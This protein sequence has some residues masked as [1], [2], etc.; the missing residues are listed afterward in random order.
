MP[1]TGHLRAVIQKG[2]KYDHEELEV[3]MVEQA[4][5]AVD[6]MEGSGQPCGAIVLECTQMPPFAEAIQKL[7][8]KPVYDVYTMGMWFYSG[9]V[10]RTP[11]MWI[12][13]VVNGN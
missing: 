2:A 4:R 7:T 5:Y 8:G 11:Q 9:L 6:D 13:E 1:S 12:S 3:E 10:R